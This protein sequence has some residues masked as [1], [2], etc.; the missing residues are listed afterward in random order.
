MNG[1]INVLKPPGMSSSGVTVFLRRILKMKRIGHAGTLDPGAAGVLVVLLGRA[2]RLSDYLMSHR[3]TYI[4]EICLGAKTDTLDS[5][6]TVVQRQDCDISEREFCSA[7]TGFVG[8][9]W[10]TPPAY[11]AVKIDGKKAYE[12]ARRGQEAKKP[13][14]KIVIH[15]LDFIRKIGKNRFLIR[16]ECSK[17]TYIRT[18]ASDIGEALRVPASLA[19]LERIASGGYHAQD[20]YTVDEIKE[21]AE[22]SDFSFVQPPESALLELPEL[23]LDESSQF[24]IENG[25]TIQK[26]APA[27][28]FRL[29]C[30]QRFYGIGGKEGKGIRLNIALYESEYGK[31]NE[32]V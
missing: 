3:K 13:P 4:G 19:F 22:K 28:Q 32:T 6:G 18:L 7:L 15:H 14:R 12:L 17:G 31:T 9:I 29:Y 26:S 16:V 23:R 24:A 10:Q 20:A 1:M 27:E 11:S 8:E 2:T 5:Y 25:Q 30:G 21:M